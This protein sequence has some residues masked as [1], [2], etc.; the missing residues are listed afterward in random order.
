MKKFLVFLSSILFLS[1]MSFAVQQ[2][3][4]SSTTQTSDTTK[5]L[6]LNSKGI[7]RSVV[8]S[9]AAANGTVTV[10][11][12]SGTANNPIAIVDATAKGSYNYE[13]YA[14]T[15]TGLTYS[16]TNAPTV[17]IVYECYY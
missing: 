7:L 2:V 12:S 1:T 8:V 17:T 3:W 14:A 13:V 6:C 4:I 10:Y 11:A 9:S 15:S 16:T 5:N